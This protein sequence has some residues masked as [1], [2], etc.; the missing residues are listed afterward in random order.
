VRVEPDLLKG[1]RPEEHEELARMIATLA[2]Q[3]FIDAS[4]LCAPVEAAA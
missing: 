2:Q 1:W 3:F 4:A